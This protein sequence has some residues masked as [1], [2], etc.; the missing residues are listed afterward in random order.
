[1]PHANATLSELGP[2]KLARFQVKS[3][4]T[5]RATAERFQVS[6]TTVVRWSRRYRAVFATGSRPGVRDMTDVSKSAA[7][8]SGP[9]QAQD[10]A[11]DHPSA[12]D[13][14][15]GSGADRRPASTVHRVLVRQSLNRLDHMDRASGE[16]I[17]RDERDRAGDPIQVDVNR[18]GRIAA[19]GGWKIHGRGFGGTR[20]AGRANARRHAQPGTGSRTPMVH[21]DETTATELGFWVCAL[22]FFTDH[23]ITLNEVLTE[24]GPVYRSR[25]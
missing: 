15:T 11:Q 3:G 16:V 23:G 22:A 14:A 13:A 10:Q 25:D 5:I 20:T 17:R 19:G 6:T 7:S 24:N 8:L 4:S 12:R 1:M 2:L 18:L 21:D 9:D